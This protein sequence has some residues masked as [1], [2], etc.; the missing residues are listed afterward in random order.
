MTILQIAQK[1]A[2]RLQLVQPTTFVGSTNNNDLFLTQM[3]YRTI[4]EIRDEFPWPELQKEYL[5][6]VINGMAAYRMPQDLNSIIFETLWNRSQQWPLLGPLDPQEWQTL[7]SGYIAALPQS[8]YRIKGWDTSQFFVNPTPSET[9]LYVFEYI[10]KSAVRPKS[11]VAGTAYTTNTYVS[12]DGIILKANGNG[13]SHTSQPPEF[14][15]DNTVFW[16]SVPSYVASISYYVDQ[17]VFANSKVYKCTDAGKGSTAPSHTSGSAVTGTCTF[18]YISTPS[19]WAGGTDYAVD[20]TV[21]G[22]GGAGTAFICSIAGISGDY[23]PKF[24]STLLDVNSILAPTTDTITDGTVT[25]TVQYPAYE[26]FQA[27]TDEVLLNNDIIIDGAVWRF[28]Q[29]RGLPYQDLKSEA[30]AR[31]ETLKTSLSSSAT[32][33]A[34]AGAGNMFPYMIGYWSYPVGNYGI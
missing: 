4:S 17:Y 27:D 31:I 8:Q 18:E 25:W 11:W 9:Q 24:N 14:G 22:T 3:L 5:F 20:D 6:S 12:S 2:G 21:T 28:K 26:T 23:S 29:E 15:R 32:L 1:C 13:T 33:S 34:R 7:K 10:S 30:E 16:K 19:A